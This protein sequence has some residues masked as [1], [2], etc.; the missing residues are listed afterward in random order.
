MNTIPSHPLLRTTLL[1]MLGLVALA[2]GAQTV[3]ALPEPGLIV[4]GRMLG[5]A[6]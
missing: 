6:T 2:C 4:Y 5:K 1:G 3:P